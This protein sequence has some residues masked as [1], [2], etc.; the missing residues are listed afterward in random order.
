M[1][2]VAGQSFSQKPLPDTLRWSIFT[3]NKKAPATDFFPTS[4]KQQHTL[5]PAIGTS[6]YMPPTAFFCRQ[7]LKLEKATRVAFRFRLGS[8]EACDQLEGKFQRK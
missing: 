2:F 6:L 7:E 4:K 5:L 3:S 1:I 8:T